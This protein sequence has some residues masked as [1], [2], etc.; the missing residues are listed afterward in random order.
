MTS[1]DT[2]TDTDKFHIDVRLFGCCGSTFRY[3]PSLTTITLSLVGVNV[4]GVGPDGLP[5]T[6]TSLRIPSGVL[7]KHTPKF[8]FLH[9]F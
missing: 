7:L 9:H 8:L 6:N 2:V 1:G 3:R 4:R 5:P